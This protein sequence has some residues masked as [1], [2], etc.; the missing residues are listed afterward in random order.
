MCEAHGEHGHQALTAG[1]DLRIIAVL[2]EQIDCL[3]DAP[4]R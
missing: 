2:G 1:E 3:L 4:G